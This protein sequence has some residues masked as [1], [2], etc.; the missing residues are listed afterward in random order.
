MN[1]FDFLRSL[2][3]GIPRSPSWEMNRLWVPFHVTDGAH[4]GD[5]GDLF[6]IGFDAALEHYISE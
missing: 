4:P 3:K 2:Y 5:G 6:G 1:A